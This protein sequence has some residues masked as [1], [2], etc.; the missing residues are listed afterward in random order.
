MNNYFH[1]FA[2]ALV[3][4]CTYGMLVMVMYADRNGDAVLKNMVLD[5]YPRMV[6]LTGGSVVFVF[7]AGIVR[8]FTYKQYEWHNAVATG[9]VEALMIK[10]VLLFILFAVGIV[11]W[12]KTHKKVKT[13]R[14]EL[15][16][17]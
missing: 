9:Q 6:H 13:F 17:R 11:L 5:L 7:V 2:T 15:S 8:S 10:H 14:K 16:R 12:V 4:V 3:V 1:D